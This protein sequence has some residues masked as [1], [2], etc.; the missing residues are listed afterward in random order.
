MYNVNDS[1]LVPSCPTSASCLRVVRWAPSTSGAS[2]PRQLSD[3]TLR[4]I[5]GSGPSE[6]RNNLF[7][8]SYHSI[9]H[10]PM[11]LPSPLSSPL[12]MSCQELKGMTLDTVTQSSWP[13]PSCL[14]ENTPKAPFQIYI[15]SSRITAS[16]AFQR[17]PRL[18][19]RDPHFTAILWT[20]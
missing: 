15:S 17:A 6:T 19:C 8:S 9:S 13:V 11:P 18:E 1:L 20:E 7:W 5:I 10:K 14:L 4:L 16:H 12:C 3:L 2:L